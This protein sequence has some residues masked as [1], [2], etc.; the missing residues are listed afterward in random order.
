MMLSS[1]HKCSVNGTRSPFSAG[2]GENIAVSGEVIT[3]ET[4]AVLEYYG[5]KTVLT[6]KDL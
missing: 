2:E 4:A 1:I 5:V 3:E 6:V